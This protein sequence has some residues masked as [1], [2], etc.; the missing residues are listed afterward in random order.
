MKKNTTNTAGNE[1]KKKEN[2]SLLYT[3]ADRYQTFCRQM[4]RDDAEL[5]RDERYTN[6]WFSY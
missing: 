5:K 4:G 2:D 3:I 6:L 1:K